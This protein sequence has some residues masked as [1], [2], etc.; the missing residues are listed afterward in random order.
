MTAKTQTTAL[1]LLLALST[2]L[3][4]QETDGTTTEGAATEEAATTTDD[5]LAMGI[6]V[7]TAE[8][9]QPYIAA[10]FESW[11]QRCLK[12]ELGADPC[13]LYYL[14]KDEQ[15]A[16]VAEFSLYGLPKGSD[17]PAVAG[18]NFMAP[19]ETLLTAGVSMQIDANPAMAYPFSVCSTAGCMARMGFSAEDI[20][21]MKAG[22]EITITVVPFVAPDQKV[23][24]KMSLKGF[25]AGMEAVDAANDA[26]DAAAAAAGA[27]AGTEG[28]EA[29]PAP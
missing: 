14:L 1:A 24:L 10:S 6:P 29:A 23:T 25:T 22:A 12:T 5:G 26:A 21:A 9:G 20:A 15:G 17:G 8:V 28:G 3:F 18:A 11:E 13:E 2:P 19:L 27:A 4:A 16:S 7:G